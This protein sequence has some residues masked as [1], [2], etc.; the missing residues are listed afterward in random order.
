LILLKKSE[1]VTLYSIGPK[2]QKYMCSFLQRE[3]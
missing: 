2:G 3:P 1:T